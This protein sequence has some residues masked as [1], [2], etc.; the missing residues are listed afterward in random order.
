[1]LAIRGSRTGKKAFAAIPKWLARIGIAAA[2]IVVNQFAHAISNGQTIAGN[3]PIRA[4][5]VSIYGN[6]DDCTGVKIASNLVLTAKHC[7]LDPSTRAIFSD[8][9]SYKITDFF[10]P[11]LRRHRDKNEYDLVIL[12]I[13]ADVGGP[14]AQIADALS[15]PKNGATAW[16]AGF[17]L[18]KIEIEVI[19]SNYSDFAVAV[20][21]K[22]GAMVCDGDSGGPAYTQE[23]NQIVVWGINSASLYGNF[24]CGSRELYTK[25]AFENAWIAKIIASNRPNS[26]TAH[27]MIFDFF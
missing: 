8:G 17:P 24:T 3:D 12:R 16:A 27:A 1:M 15:T 9:G 25:L 4:L 19:D 2:L 14:V 10:L 20:R 21:T 13:D 6:D 18:R 23:N 26:P 11:N 7:K 22:K 5:S